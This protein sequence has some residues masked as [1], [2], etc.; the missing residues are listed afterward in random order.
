MNALLEEMENPRLDV[1]LE[2]KSR[3]L[4]EIEFTATQAESD[5]SVNV[6]SREAIG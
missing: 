4:K 2:P 6:V 1:W 3:F 5:T